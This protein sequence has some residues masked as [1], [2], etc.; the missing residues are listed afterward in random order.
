MSFPTS[1]PSC[2]KFVRQ[3]ACM[4]GCRNN[5]AAGVK[6]NLFGIGIN[7][8]NK[9]A[10][11]ARKV[12]SVLR[13]APFSPLG[14]PA[15]GAS[16][17]VA[18]RTSEGAVRADFRT[19]TVFLGPDRVLFLQRGEVIELPRS[20]GNS[21]PGLGYTGHIA[22]STTDQFGLTRFTIST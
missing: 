12:R 14:A 15:L 16:R 1:R 22:L 18:V 13:T 8:P 6:R 2:S 10:M 4:F 19:P 3:W 11:G 9:L 7:P 5:L 21:P 17:F 20:G